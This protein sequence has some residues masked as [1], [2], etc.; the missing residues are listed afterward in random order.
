M[1]PVYARPPRIPA[2]SFTSQ[3]PGGGSRNGP[4][5]GG[6]AAKRGSSEAG[7][8]GSMSKRAKQLSTGVNTYIEGGFGEG[9]QPG[10]R[11]SPRPKVGGRSTGP[12]A[13]QTPPNSRGRDAG[14]MH[15][16]G[17][18]MFEPMG[19]A[20]VH[21]LRQGG[22]G[23]EYSELGFFGPDY[24]PGPGFGPGLGF[25]PGPGFATEPAYGGQSMGGRVRGPGRRRSRG[26]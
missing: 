8:T 26:R 24:G 5:T 18:T 7:I 23:P 3:P 11:A 15:G 6:N 19:P 25:A 1:R 4:A 9:I 17:G 13:M 12:G 16:G 21:P 20:S 10:S 2:K 22:P 14:S